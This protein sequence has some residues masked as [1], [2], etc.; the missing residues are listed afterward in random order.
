[1]GMGFK[2]R[3][4]HPRHN[5]TRVP[6]WEGFPTIDCEELKILK[7]ECYGG[8]GSRWCL[9]SS[10]GA[11]PP[12]HNIHS[13][14]TLLSL[15]RYFDSSENDMNI[16]LKNLFVDPYI[17]QSYPLCLCIFPIQIWVLEVITFCV[18]HDPLLM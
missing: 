16:K 2:A 4:S 9:A 1:M 12:M 10:W 8:G 5:Q 15:R 6:P 3:A 17:F 14:D 7:L 11:R 18:K 13:M